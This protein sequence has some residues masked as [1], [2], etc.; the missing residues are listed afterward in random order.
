[1]TTQPQ[2][3]RVV[4][5]IS[6]SRFLMFVACVCFFAAAVIT[7]GASFPPGPALAWAFGGFSAWCLASVL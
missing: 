2:S 6:V 7:C 4:H 1:M 3:G 5:G